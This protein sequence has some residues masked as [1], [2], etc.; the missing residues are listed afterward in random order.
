MFDPFADYDYYNASRE[1]P[2][3][4]VDSC[5]KDI[6]EMA[7]QSAIDYLNDTPS[8]LS[9]AIGGESYR[10]YREMDAAN[11]RLL[12]AAA[13]DDAAAVLAEVKRRLTE[14]VVDECIELLRQHQEVLTV[15][16]DY[17]PDKQQGEL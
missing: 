17:Y 12:L 5:D 13:E 2:H 15:G 10:D 6:S 11:Q 1:W 9:E 7:W 3:L 16:V 4:T 8:A 14:Y